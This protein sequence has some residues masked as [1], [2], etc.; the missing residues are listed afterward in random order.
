MLIFA[1]G[2]LAQTLTAQATSGLITYADPIN[3]VTLQYP[4][5]WNKEISNTQNFS[6]VLNSPNNSG[7]IFGTILRPI[8]ADQLGLAE[9]MTLDVLVKSIAL[10]VGALTLPPNE[11]ATLGVNI[12]EL[13]SEGYFLSGHPAGRIVMA[14]ASPDGTSKMMALATT[15]N[16]GLYAIS[17][18]A[19]ATT[20]N[21][22]LADAET[23][24]DS[25]KII[26]GQ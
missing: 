26:S 4:D 25:F 22:H 8:P 3:G 2:S 6:F 16:D 11:L 17:Y 23:I 19:D 10:P 7:K 24:I 5:S 20:Y 12:L 15:V 13:N 18:M 14:L 9:N 21:Q 1:V